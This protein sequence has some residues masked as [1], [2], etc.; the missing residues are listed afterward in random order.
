M[1]T[2]LMMRC[3]LSL[4]TLLLLLLSITPTGAEV[5]QSISNCDQFFLGQTPPEIPGILV[6]VICQTYENE[7]RFVTLYDTEN[8][9]PVFSAY[10]YE[11]DDGRRPNTTW[12]I[13]PQ[14]GSKRRN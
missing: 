2:S 8:K 10:K 11:G 1:T 3:L 4:A 6:D 7:K 5:V 9:I 14:V 12:M 13:E